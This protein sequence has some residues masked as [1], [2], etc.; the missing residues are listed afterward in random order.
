MEV[1]AS[2][3]GPT[4]PDTLLALENY[5]SIMVTLERG[6]EVRGLLERALVALRQVGPTS[7]TTASAQLNLAEALA[8][9]HRFAE[10]VTLNR[11]ALAILEPLTGGTHPFIAEGL[12]NLGIDTLGLDRPDDAVAPLERA[13]AIHVKLAS[14]PVD[15]AM[16]RFTLARALV[17][18][19]PERARALAE[20]ARTAYADVAKQF[21]GHAAVR[22]GQVTAWIAAHVK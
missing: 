18:R 17:E 12:T 3:L 11:E 14:T 21:G 13:L 9:D 1:Q 8:E 6:R 5:G 4:H 2:V 10:A 20:A 22:A 19:D 15:A 7:P 16:T